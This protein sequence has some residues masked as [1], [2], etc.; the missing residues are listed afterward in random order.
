MHELCFFVSAYPERPRVG[1][2]DV[3]ASYLFQRG[4]VLNPILLIQSVEKDK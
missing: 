3:L 2:C 4:V 1:P